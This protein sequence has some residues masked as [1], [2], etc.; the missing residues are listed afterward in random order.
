[1]AQLLHSPLEPHPIAAYAAKPERRLPFL[2]SCVVYALLGSLGYRHLLQEQLRALVPPT[3]RPERI[4]V[5]D[6]A[7]ML[8]EPPL[9]KPAP[10]N[11]GRAEETKPLIPPGSGSIDEQLLKFR[12]VDPLPDSAVPDFLPTELPTPT[13]PSFLGSKQLPIAKG[14]DGRPKAGRGSGDGSGDGPPGKGSLALKADDLDFVNYVKPDYPGP[15]ITARVEGIV[16]VR[17]TVSEDGLPL[18]AKA[19]SGPEVLIPNTLKAVKKWRFGSLHRK[20]VR[21]TA[22]VDVSV[23]FLLVNA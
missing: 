1:M 23:L 5:I 14:G 8:R 12:A 11:Q 7:R 16:W 3:T 4:Y 20:G 19:I 22:T 21:G 17:V 6:L 10:Q 15:A 9:Q 13:T 2:L 18:E